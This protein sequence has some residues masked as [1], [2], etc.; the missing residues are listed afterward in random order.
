MARLGR[1]TEFGTCLVLGLGKFQRI[2]VGSFSW[3]DNG[4]RRTG[5]AC[6]VF[7]PASRLFLMLKFY[8]NLIITYYSLVF[9]D[10]LL[11][12]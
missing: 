2:G 11:F 6:G 7:G 3:R 12:P 5:V 10:F 9:V 8:T 4:E 1:G